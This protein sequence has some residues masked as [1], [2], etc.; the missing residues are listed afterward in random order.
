MVTSGQ[1]NR[2]THR[3]MPREAGE[4]YK[5]PGDLGNLNSP[6]ADDRAWQQSGK[7]H[8]TTEH[9]SGVP[10]EATQIG[11]EAIAELGS[12]IHGGLANRYKSTGKWLSNLLTIH[13]MLTTQ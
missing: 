5:F 2:G 13:K 1:C 10:E 7:H 11:R 4:S 12:F 3:S 9:M 6:I 8:R